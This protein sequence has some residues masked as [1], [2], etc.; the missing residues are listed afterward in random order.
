MTVVLDISR[1]ISR[2]HF[3]TPTGIDRFELSYARWLLDGESAPVFIETRASGSTIVRSEVARALISRVSRRWAV[4]TMSQREELQLR[5]IAAAIEGERPWRPPRPGQ[6][7][8]LS[9]LSNSM[10]Q[11]AAGA[12]RRA[13]P[14]WRPVPAESAFIHVSHARLHC[15]A[16]FSWLTARRPLAVFYIHD[17]IPLSHP[18]FVRLGEPER[19]MRRMSTVLSHA[20]L[21]LCNSRMTAAML[22]RLAERQG[23]PQPRSAVLPPGVTEVFLKAPGNEEQYQPIRTKRPYFVCIGTIEPRKN[24]ALLL[25]LWRRLLERQ[26][27]KAPR[28]VIVG[29]RGWDNAELFKFLDNPA[30]LQDAIIEVPDLPD[31]PLVRLLTG[32]SALLA[33]SFV[34]GYG[35][36]VAEALAV[37]TPVIASRIDAHREIAY[38]ATT[39]LDPL[40]GPEWLQSIE[41]HAARHGNRRPHGVPSNTRVPWTWPDHFRALERLMTADHRMATRSR[42]TEDD[43]P[44]YE[45]AR[46]SR[47]GA[48]PL[49]VGW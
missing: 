49:P 32:A 17:L 45:I 13:F 21:I 16:S 23:L 26:G 5:A 22:D 29:R 37:G 35:M 27:P 34:E 46:R 44:A 25:K 10:R 19:H 36:P 1:L 33:P 41:A 40:D 4:T 30:T 47:P 2:Q 7:F 20:S 28:L 3:A 12:I 38:G 18:E 48:R 8:D 31:A 42:E 15:P 24:H 39:L 6:T 14:P 43:E 11:R 9:A